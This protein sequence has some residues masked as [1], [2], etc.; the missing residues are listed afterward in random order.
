MTVA[1]MKETY[2]EVTCKR[3]G[4]WHITRAL[5]RLLVPVF[6]GQLAWQNRVDPAFGSEELR[7]ERTDAIGLADCSRSH[8]VVSM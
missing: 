3:P 5:F 7:A 2:R 4:S 6:D 8:P 1:Q